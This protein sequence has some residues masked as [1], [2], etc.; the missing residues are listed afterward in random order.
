L[1]RV[2][3]CA[4]SLSQLKDG[5]I[6]HAIKQV[7]SLS[8]QQDGAAQGIRP[9]VVV[10]HAAQGSFHAAQD[11][12]DGVLEVAPNEVGIHDDR[13]VRPAVIDAARGVVV[14]AAGL[15]QGSVIGDH[16]VYRP[17]CNA[18]KQAGFAQARD[19]RCRVHLRLGNDAHTVASC[20]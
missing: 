4:Q 9:V 6:R 12:R 2:F 17:A 8:I 3:A 20:H 16:R 11:N 10:H 7:V 13:S 18:P 1:G 14:A 19:I 15:A 5:E